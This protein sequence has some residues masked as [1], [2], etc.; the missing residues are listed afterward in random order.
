MQRVAVGSTN[1]AKIEAV[2]RAFDELYPGDFALEPVACD[3]GNAQ[4]WG[5]DDTRR[6]ALERARAARAGTG[7]DWG[8]GLEGGLV[9]DAGGILVTSWIAA[10]EAGGEPGLA[11]T[12]GFYL[13]P[14]IADR[15]LAG[16]DLAEAWRQARGLERVGRGGGTV[17]LLTAGWIDRARL[18]GEAVMLAVTIARARE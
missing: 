9:S 5:E 7:A 14:A 10:C 12:A 2:H 11:R 18:Y 3:G 4:P 15:V 8:I 13:P 1:P 17:G 6:G 16:H